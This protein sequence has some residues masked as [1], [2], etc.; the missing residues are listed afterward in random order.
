MSY[1]STN[2]PVP[3]PAYDEE[4]QPFLGGNNAGDDMFKETVANSSKQVR[5]QFVRKVYSI[6]AVQLLATSALSATYMFNQT[7]KHW[8]QTNVWMLYV[9]MFGTIG[10]LFALFWKARSFPL[11][12]TFLGLF[13]LLE[14]HLVGAIVTFYDQQIV[15]K[16]LLITL[17][18]FVGLTLFTLQSK[19]DFSGLAP[20][21]MG[22]IWVLII[23]GLIQMFFPFSK[24]IELA[25]AVGGVVIFSGYI[26]FDTYLIFNKYS[27]EDYI[28]ASVSLYLDVINL[29]LRI[30][31]ILDLT[32]RSD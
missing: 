17:G 28:L 29:F 26:L 27:P 4:N 13:T 7:A 10:V 15:L 2:Y 22:G 8:V 6:L 32:S 24:E 23:A 21:L 5:L 20:F 1:G 19:W 16:A 9:S 18:V 14:A 11:N 12:Y 25:L 3:P 31:E 30:L